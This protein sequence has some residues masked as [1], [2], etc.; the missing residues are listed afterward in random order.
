MLKFNCYES[1]TFM[2]V[3]L[4]ITTNDLHDENTMFEIWPNTN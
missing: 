2:Q 3:S 4:F 1:I